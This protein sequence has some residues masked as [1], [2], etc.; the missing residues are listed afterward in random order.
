[1]ILNGKTLSLPA[2]TAVR[3][4]LISR[5]YDPARVAVERDGE[6]IRRTD[7]DTVMLTDNDRV[8]VVQFVGGG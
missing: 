6:I 8:E 4:F 2:P 7:F 5:G 1:M 3:D